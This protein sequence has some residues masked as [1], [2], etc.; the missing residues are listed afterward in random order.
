MNNINDAA[1]AII[2]NIVKKSARLFIA[3]T[4]R[5]V[6][7][8]ASGYRVLNLCA[9]RFAVKVSAEKV[10]LGPAAG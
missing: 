2:T 10:S 3:I 7:C 4:N 1:A 9:I 5:W 8:P 6:V